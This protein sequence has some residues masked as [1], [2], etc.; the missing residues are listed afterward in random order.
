[1]QEAAIAL[2]GS[3]APA[4]AKINSRARGML[5]VFIGMAAT[6]RQVHLTSESKTLASLQIYDAN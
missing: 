3:I 6:F 4:K 2:S 1:L 5:W